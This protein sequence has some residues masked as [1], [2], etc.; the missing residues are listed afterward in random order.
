MPLKG[1][2]LGEGR[3]SPYAR[4]GLVMTI[5]AMIDAAAV[6]RYGARM[7]EPM[8]PYRTGWIADD[9]TFGARLALVRQRMGWGNIKEAAVACG[10]PVESWRRWERDGR[11]PHNVIKRAWQIAERTGCDYM[12]LLH[13]PKVRG[14]QVRREDVEAL[15]NPERAA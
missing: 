6:M 9:S 2:S 13:G 1:R 11:K 4:F 10:V 12:W 5:R 8:E 7:A 15:I 14:L 3:C